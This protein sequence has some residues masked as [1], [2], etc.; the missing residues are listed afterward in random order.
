[1]RT[2]YLG[3]LGG[4]LVVAGCGPSYGGNP[5]KTPDQ[6]VAEQE[7]LG[8]QEQ[9]KSDDDSAPDDVNPDDEE[10]Q[11]KPFD[12]HQAKLELIRAA[13]SAQTCVGVVSKDSPQGK[14]TVTLLFGNDGHVKKAS[15]GPPFD[16]TEMGKC[17]IN[18]MKAVIVPPFKG[19]TVSMDWDVDLSPKKK[20]DD[21]KE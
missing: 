6:I 18:A 11:T 19:D 12:K 8:K 16:G 7:Q 21:S 15:I 14:G 1:M 9:S 3:L 20:D 2:W 17:A 4:V 10:E 5:V 13:R